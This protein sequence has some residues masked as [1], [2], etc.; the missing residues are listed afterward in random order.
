RTALLNEVRVTL[1]RFET[2]RP[3]T[4]NP[5]FWISHLLGGLHHLLLRRDRTPDARAAALCGRLEDVPSLL[6]AARGSPSAPVPL[7][8][9]TAPELWRY[10]HGLKDEILADLTERANRLDGKRP[11]PDVA[12]RLRQDHPPAESLVAAYAKEM[13]RAREF[14]AARRLAPIPDAPLNVVP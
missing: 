9:D 4:K 13:E 10:G 6:K 2:E 11:W 14:V 3:Q 8:A 7:H 5:E 1:H 12:D